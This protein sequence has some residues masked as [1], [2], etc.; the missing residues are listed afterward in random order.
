MFEP[1]RRAIVR[2]ALPPA[3]TAVRVVPSQL[4]GDVGV[5]GAAAVALRVF[6]V[7]G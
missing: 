2:H 7:Q 4:G 6:E 3:A 1:L 5:L